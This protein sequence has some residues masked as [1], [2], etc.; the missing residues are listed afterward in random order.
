MVQGVQLVVSD[1]EF[2]RQQ[3]LDRGV[4]VT[5][6]QHFE[7][8]KWLDGS[9]GRWNC[10]VFPRIQTATTGLYKRGPRKGDVHR[11]GCRRVPDG[12]G[13]DRPDKMKVEPDR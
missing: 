7:D 1:L 6:I 9:G 8:G 4:E 11:C 13:K 2:A 10:F 12:E 3:L 5:G